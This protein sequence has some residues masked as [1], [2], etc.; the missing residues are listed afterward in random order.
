MRV[1]KLKSDKSVGY[2]QKKKIGF[3]NVYFVF[4]FGLWFDR[5]IEKIVVIDQKIVI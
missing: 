2:F 5:Y 4:I 1:L 3:V